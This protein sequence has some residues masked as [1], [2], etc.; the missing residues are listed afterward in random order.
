VPKYVIE[1]ESSEW[2]IPFF[3]W[4]WRPTDGSGKTPENPQGRHGAYPARWI[5]VLLAKL[6]T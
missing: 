5:A 2:G 1:E 4:F 6:H 3:K